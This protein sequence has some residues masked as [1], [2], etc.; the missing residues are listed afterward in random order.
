[1]LLTG[2]LSGSAAVIADAMFEGVKL[3]VEKNKPELLRKVIFTVFQPG[4]LQTF[5]DTL[6]DKVEKDPTLIQRPVSKYCCNS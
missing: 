4:M 1:M 3:F 6:R 2:L 5:I